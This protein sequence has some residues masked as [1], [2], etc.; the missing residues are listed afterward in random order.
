M[1]VF[2]V[3]WVVCN[4]VSCGVCIRTLFY[5][6]KATRSEKEKLFSN[7]KFQEEILSKLASVSEGN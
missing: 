2:L 4:F 5:L 7:P 6:R 1:T 3:L